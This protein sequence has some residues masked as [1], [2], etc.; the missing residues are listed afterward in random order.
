MHDLRG[1]VLKYFSGHP[2]TR[3]TVKDLAKRINVSGKDQFRSL[4]T[5]MEELERTG[6]LVADA[7]GRFSYARQRH[8]AEHTKP[9]VATGR[10]SITRRGLGFVKAD[11]WERDIR[12]APRFLHAAFSGDLVEVALF[13]EPRA[14]RRDEGPEGEI[15][16][17]L[18]RTL[19]RVTGRLE[20]RKDFAIV[21]PD[22][23]RVPR[24]IYLTPGEAQKARSGDKV[25]VELEPWEDEH[26]NPG[27][28]IVEVLGPAGDAR[29]EVLSVARSFGLP[30]A[31]PGAVEHAAAGL[32]GTIPAD[33]LSRRL[34]LR[35]STCVTIDPEDAKD[36]DDALS[37]EVLP[38]GNLKLGVHIADVSY[39]V[40][41]ESEL[42]REA[43]A[44]GTSVYLVNE[45]I[46][47]LPE[48]LSNDLCSLRPDSDRLTYSA[49]M[50]VTKD[51]KV[52]AY[53]FARSVIH[54]ARRFAYEE[55]QSI[56][57][58]G[59]GDHADLLLRLNGLAKQLYKRRRKTGSL[60]FDTAEAKFRFDAQG[61]PSQIIKKVRLDAHRLVEECML[62]ANKVVAQHVAHMKTGGEPYPFLYRV[63]DLPNPERLK[64]LGTFVKQFGFSLDVKNGV[65]SRALQKL[66]DDVKGTE[67]EDVIHDVA[68]RTMAKA[69]YAE[70]NIG[71]Y[72]LGFRHYAH[73]TSPIRR[74][75]DLIVHRLLAEY[76][77]TPASARLAHLREI[78]PDVARQSSDRERVAVE[79]ERES[80]KVM[81]IEYMKRHIGDE[82]EGVITG[83][84]DF[85]LFVELHDLLI[86][87]LV[88]VRDLDDDYYLFDEKQYALK[89]RSR[90]RQ[91]R[92]GDVVRVRTVSVNAESRELNLALVAVTTRN[93]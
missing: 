47:M 14:H 55:V 51:G 80:V 63:H 89:G 73:F 54:S 79:A 68:L 52:E 25:V 88:H 46:P 22:D 11:G 61:L 2:R 15:V 77:T 26:L 34:D 1:S 57:E 10:L 24:D 9:R 86:Q 44:R 76:A 91:Y 74:Y 71:H 32:P 6:V 38:N 82:F 42:D 5:L 87:G 50:E 30:P 53:Q 90:G 31:F 49:L 28:T 78:M 41:E 39:Y 83:V 29:V 65:S 16:R 40:R 85:G 23:E 48:R 27:G 20:M 19:T 21:I 62:L 35:S 12:I 84:T 18:E 72:G 7:H 45:V 70:K 37:C 92:L 66:L 13:A 67:V 64:D 60:D 81:Q 33:E 75:P 56:L 8:R 3:S 93:F 17:V 43:Y 59:K 58:K 69:V 36:F 4:R